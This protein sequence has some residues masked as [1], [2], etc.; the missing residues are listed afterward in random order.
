MVSIS[1]A[2]D[3]LNKGDMEVHAGLNGEIYRIPRST[4]DKEVFT[5]VPRQV[6]VILKEAGYHVSSAL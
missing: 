4:P 1:V 2:Q 5:E 6:A 3:P